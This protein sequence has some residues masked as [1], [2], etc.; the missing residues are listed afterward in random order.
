MGCGGSTAQQEPK[1]ADKYKEE[2]AKEKKE[3][4]EATTKDAT[5]A[6]KEAS[7]APVVAAAAAGGA[8]AA[9]GAASGDTPQ[10]AA[11][12]PATADGRKKN[13]PG[14]MMTQVA[15]AD[16]DVCL[17]SAFGHISD[18]SGLTIATHNTKTDETFAVV[19]NDDELT[20]V[21]DALSTP[22]LPWSNFWK[23]LSSAITKGDVKVSP[24]AQTVDIRMKQSKGEPKEVTLSQKLT[25]QASPYEFF[26]KPIGK[27][28]KAKQDQAAAEAKDKK[29]DKK[30]KETDIQAKESIYNLHESILLAGAE[31]QA[32]HAPSVNITR[33][34]ANIAKL[35]VGEL[36]AKIAKTKLELETIVTGVPS[37]PLDT[38]YGCV[39]PELPAAGS[40]DVPADPWTV[41][42]FSISAPLCDVALALFNKHGLI[43]AFSMDA[44]LVRQYF[45]FVESKCPKD[46]QYNGVAHAKD[47]M[48][49]MD[50]VIGACLEKV[51]FSKEDILAGLLSAGILDF[52]DGFDSAHVKASGCTISMLYSDVYSINQSN[53]TVAA[54]IFYNEKT[55]L[56][57]SLTPDQAKDVIE[58]VRELLFIKANVQLKS[59]VER[60]ED[61]SKLATGG[62]D[63]STKDNIRFVL[64]QA[65]RLVD[66][67]AFGKQA[68]VHKGLAEKFAEQYYRQGDEEVSL[69]L[70]A[71]NFYGTSWSTDRSQHDATFAR[72]MAQFMKEYCLPVYEALAKVGAGLSDGAANVV[73]NAEAYDTVGGNSEPKFV[74]A[75][76]ALPKVFAD[77]GSGVLL[78]R[79]GPNPR[80]LWVT[81]SSADGTWSAYVDDIALAKL[82]VADTAEFVKGLPQAAAQGSI[83]GSAGSVTVD[84]KQLT[85]SEAPEGAKH[86]TIPAI[87]SYLELRGLSAMR[88]IDR[89]LDEITGKAELAGDQAGYIHGE[90]KAL[91]GCVDVSAKKIAELEGE[92][93]KIAAEYTGKGGTEVTTAIEDELAIGVRNPL[94]SP[95]A[96][97]VTQAPDQKTVDFELLKIVKSRFFMKSDGAEKD[98]T[99]EPTD[100]PCCNQIMP[101]LTTDFAKMTSAL[102]DAKR[103]KIYDQLLNLD[104]WSYDVFDLQ[105]EMSGGIEGENLRNQPNGG[106][107]FIT[108]YGLMYK[109]QFMQKFNIDERVFLNFLSIV[110][111]GYHPNP[112]H[113]S[114]HAADV[115]HVVHYIMG[116][117]GARDKLK[118]TDE[119]AFAGLFAATIHDYNHP[120]INNAFHVRSQNYLAVLFND[121]SVNENIHISSIFELMRMDKFNILT[122]F[123]GDAYV[124]MR[125]DIVALVLGTDMGLHAMILSR[126]KKRLEQTEGKLYKTKADKILGL[127][128]CVKMADINNCGR[129]Q[130]LYHGWCNVI[131][132]EFFQQGDRERLYGLPVSPFMDRYTT[133]MAKGQI[134]FMNYIVM[135]LFECMGEF[136]E[137]MAVASQLAEENKSFWQENEDW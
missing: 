72:G 23:M 70:A 42:P 63:F 99:E 92:Y 13:M 9:G 90:K 11:E 33:D 73:K 98:L 100:A 36:K 74:E 53:V 19:L 64:T 129:P 15:L 12:L 118:L 102:P 104:S 111:A 121:R 116:P 51:K 97:G 32:V 65:V 69:G 96:A 54:E 117:G 26:F 8:V 6:K 82:G 38:M 17:V 106:A 27:V 128:M 85:L 114:M 78:A 61:F 71:T 31:A 44:E 108:M 52:V 10:A 20:A 91:V 55:N 86:Q 21:R 110:E 103:Q 123:K 46:T 79:V 131:V 76:A 94:K 119:E 48:L 83:S 81:Y 112:Y 137:G 107:L 24:C 125:D 35:R 89:K 50:H 4:T 25:S 3:K 7:P 60:L 136:F 62:P 59:P 122:A 28:F 77:C 41:D 68:D 115:L 133:V 113:N 29:D 135:P 43:E 80:H 39:L 5:P 93:S 101:Y 58:S 124:K 2:P 127:T 47:A 105:T 75:L 45:N 56:L 14:P 1:A 126:F 37:H 109:Y 34:E 132:D 130:K 134:G 49:T 18:L 66:W 16:K 84:G 57:A 30:L 40:F 88:Y 22:P 120:G 87:K 67:A 95:L